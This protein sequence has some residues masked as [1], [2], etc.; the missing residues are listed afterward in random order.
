M[1]NNI[2]DKINKYKYLPLIIYDIMITLNMFCYCLVAALTLVFYINYIILFSAKQST[3]VSFFVCLFTFSIPKAVSK[4]Y[5]KQFL[6]SWFICIKQKH[7]QQ[8]QNHEEKH[9]HYNNNLKTLILKS[10]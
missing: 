4:S 9:Y 5:T 2:E 3:Q 1:R 8:Q 6:S 10:N 7:H